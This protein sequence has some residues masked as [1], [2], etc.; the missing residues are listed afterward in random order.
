[1]FAPV[2]DNDVEIVDCDFSDIRIRS[3]QTVINME[4]VEGWYTTKVRL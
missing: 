2:A 4:S 3:F 1:M